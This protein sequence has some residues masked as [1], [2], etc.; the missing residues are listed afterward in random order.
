MQSGRQE[1]KS[2]VLVVGSSNAD[3]YLYVPRLPQQGETLQATLNL[4]KSSPCLPGGK[5]LNQAVSLA[6]LGA[7]V[8]FCSMFGDD[9][10]GMFLQKVLITEGV[11]FETLSTTI[12][13]ES[14]GKAF[15]FSLPDGDNSIVIVAGANDHWPMQEEELNLFLQNVFNS[16]SGVHAVL[17]QREI[18]DLVNLLV[19]KYAFENGKL[20]FM[21]AGGRAT[22][23]DPRIWP[24]IHVFSPNRTE[25]ARLSKLPTDTEDDI[26]EA[27]KFI[28]EKGVS[29]VL[30]KLG[31]QGSLMICRDGSIIR[32]KAVFVDSADIID[33]V[34]AGDCF[35][36]A[37]TVA[38]V[39]NQPFAAAMHF[40]SKAAA[41]SIQ[42]K[43]AMSSMPFRRQINE[44]C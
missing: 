26:I 7:D 42:K 19:A 20:V 15:I 17:L 41:I 2:S 34:G 18:P 35:T 43:Y 36:A 3:V 1:R 14:T 25:L 28:Q 37:F 40:A 22:D 29:N 31:D 30:V 33:T 21:D 12:P 8:L 5:G 16:M 44:E 13:G 10:E 11:N 24:Y 38:V 4:D 32:E 27:A 39:E 9:P 6:R 23:I